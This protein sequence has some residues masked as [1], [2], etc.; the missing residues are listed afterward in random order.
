MV[1]PQTGAGMSL[2]SSGM[3]RVFVHRSLILAPLLFVAAG[4]VAGC[5]GMGDLRDA[6]WFTRQPRILGNSLALETPPLTPQRTIAPDDL[7]SADGM[8][9]GMA[10][11]SE[12]NAMTATDPAAADPAAAAPGWSA[13]SR[14]TSV[15]LVIV[16]LPS[17]PRARAR[18]RAAR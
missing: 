17:L 8:C 4:S 11:A 2:G 3:S 1:M 6:E 15:A 16:L 14:S 7:I 9:S 10:P 18:T 5:S 12:A 13:R